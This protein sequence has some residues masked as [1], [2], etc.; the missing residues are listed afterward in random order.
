MS[1]CDLTSIGIKAPPATSI[2][3]GRPQSFSVGLSKSGVPNNMMSSH[4]SLPTCLRSGPTAMGMLEVSAISLTACSSNARPSKILWCCDSSTRSARVICP[5]SSNQNAYGQ[6]RYRVKSVLVTQSRVL[7]TTLNS[8]H[9]HI[10]QTL[11]CQA[12][13]RP[14][15]ESLSRT[16]TE[17]QDKTWLLLGREGY[18]RRLTSESNQS[19]NGYAHAARVGTTRSIWAADLRVRLSMVR[20]RDSNPQ[21]P[22]P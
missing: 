20:A 15:V 3:S 18:P 22:D 4:S 12:R 6:R 17:W 10:S 14:P 11:M 13:R 5:W 16:V 8:L 2:P 1:L 7:R 9:Q 19:G 21:P